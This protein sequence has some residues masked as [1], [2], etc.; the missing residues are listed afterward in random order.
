MPLDDGDNAPRIRI[1][2][3]MNM[4]KNEGTKKRSREA[5]GDYTWSV[6]DKV[7]AWI[8]NG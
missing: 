2:H 6:G 1:P 7:D 3:P 5:R 8:R 4:L